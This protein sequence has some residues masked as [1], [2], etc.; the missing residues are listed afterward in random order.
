ME[1]IEQ[2]PNIREVMKAM[3]AMARMGVSSEATNRMYK[4][5]VELFPS[6]TPQ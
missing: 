4:V 2:D 6:L 3:P 5:L 1:R